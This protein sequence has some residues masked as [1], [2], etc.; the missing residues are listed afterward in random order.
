MTRCSIDCEPL[1]NSMI[2][3]RLEPDPSQRAVNQSANYKRVRENEEDKPSDKGSGKTEP[4][5]SGEFTDVEAP[6]FQERSHKQNN[7]D[8]NNGIEDKIGRAQ[9]NNLGRACAQAA[10]SENGDKKNRQRYFSR[11]EPAI[12]CNDFTIATINLA[13]E[14]NVNVNAR[15]QEKRIRNRTERAEKIVAAHAGLPTER[16]SSGGNRRDR[17]RAAGEVVW[18]IRFAASIDSFLPARER[19]GRD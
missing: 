19:N 5:Q 12:G 8:S 7:S 13:Q 1:N 4:R 6:Q 17:S 10:E 14:R 16:S 9:A 3:W 11:A 18:A 2:P 15:D